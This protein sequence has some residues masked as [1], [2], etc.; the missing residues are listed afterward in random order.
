MK[1]I[2]PV[3]CLALVA[4]CAVL[5]VFVYRATTTN[6]VSRPSEE[7]SLIVHSSSEEST[8]SVVSTPSKPNYSVAFTENSN[9]KNWNVKWDIISGGSIINTYS[10][11]EKITFGDAS[12]YN[13]VQGITTF[14]GNNYRTGATFGETVVINKTLTTVWTKSVSSLK[15]TGCGWTGQPLVV[16]WNEETKAIMNLKPEKKTKK[17]LVEAIYATLDGHIYF[18]DMEDGSYT[19]DPIW[20][21]MNFKGSGAIDPRGY[22]LMYVGSGDYRDGKAPRMY[23]ISLIDGKILHEQSGKD[24]YIKRSGGW[25][26]FDG[27]PIVDAETD[28]LIWPGESGILY[29]IKLHTNYDKTAGTISIEPENIVKTRYTDNS[30]KRYGYESSVVAVGE[31]LYIGDNHGMFY[32]VNANTMA[33]VWAQNLKDDLNGSPVFECDENGKGYLYIGTS[34][35]YAGGKSYIYKIDASNGEIVWTKTY[36][37]IKYDENVSGGVLGSPVLGKKGTPLE[38][39]LIIPVGKTENSNR[40]ILVALNKNTGEVMWEKK[41]GSYTWS[42]PTAIYTKDGNAYIIVCTAM[43]GIYLLDG[44]NGETL[45][46]L[47][48]GST[49]E[50]SPVVFENTV[51]IGT[52]GQKVFGIEIG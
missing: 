11:P 38:N 13:Q 18:Y 39:M 52:R 24:S 27:S 25:C 8:S 42:S 46:N 49:V 14:R 37:N 33:L 7:S 26:A 17:D 21:G 32:C 3:I 9:P 40:G 44:S 41:M 22:P 36:E 31:Y 45:A 47:S 6:D 19:R 50:A 2:I 43:G 15:W 28:T 23:I 34:M 1:R 30:G 29:T 5:S 51:I 35:E 20:V 12:E 10:R 4:V 16:R 48:L